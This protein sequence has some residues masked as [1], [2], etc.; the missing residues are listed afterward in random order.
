MGYPIRGLSDLLAVHRNI[1][2]RQYPLKAFFLYTEDDEPLNAY[3]RDHF[4]E[5]DRTSG[6]LL[7]FLINKPPEKWL[8]D[9][10]N[11]TYS[12]IS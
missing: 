12:L 3:I 6:R 7:F 11:R 9:A 10:S 5:L 4:M 8:N 2:D 1:D